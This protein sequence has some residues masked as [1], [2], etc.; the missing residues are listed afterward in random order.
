MSGRRWWPMRVD[1]FRFFGG[2]HCETSALWK[3]LAF[4]GGQWSE[5]MLLGIGGGIGFF[6]CQGNGMAAPFIG[7]RCGGRESFPAVICERLG[8]PAYASQ[9]A[10]AEAAHRELQ[11]TIAAGEPA[12]VYG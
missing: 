5:E 11:E 8:V 9:T 3:L 1:G 6:Y 2:L 7:T 4:H 12:I 10:G